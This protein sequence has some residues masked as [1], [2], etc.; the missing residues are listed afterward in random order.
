MRMGMVSLMEIMAPV[1]A[2]LLLPLSFKLLIAN[3]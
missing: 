3:C 1:L 2:I